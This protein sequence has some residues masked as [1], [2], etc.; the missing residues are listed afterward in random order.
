[1]SCLSFNVILLFAL[2]LASEGLVGRLLVSAVTE[3]GTAI[4]SK[5]SKDVAAYSLCTYQCKSHG[6]GMRAKGGDLRQKW[7]RF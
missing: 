6:E 1:M 3:F 4:E 5:L 2:P 7:S